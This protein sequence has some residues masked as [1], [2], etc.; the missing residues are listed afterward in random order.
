MAR[1]TQLVGLWN[2]ALTKALELPRRPR[3]PRR[4]LYTGSEIAPGDGRSSTRRWSRS[5][6]RSRT[7][8]A[9]TAA[10]VEADER[11]H[12]RMLRIVLVVSLLV[13]IAFAVVI[14][15]S[16]VK[17]VREL[18]A[19]LRSLDEHCLSELTAGLEAA[20]AGDFTRA[21]VTTPLA[22][23]ADDELGRLSTTFNSMLGKAQRSLEAYTAMCGELG[24]AD[25]RG[26]TQRRRGVGRLGAGRG[27]LRRGRPCRRRDR[28]RRHRRRPRRRAPGADGRVDPRPE[29]T[30]RRRQR[31]RDLHRR[32]PRTRAASPA[33]ASP[34]P[35]HERDPRGRRRLGRDR[36]RDRGPLRPLGAHRRDRDHDH[37]A[38]RAARGV[39]RRSARRRAEP[40]HPWVRGR[41]R[42]ANAG[43][44]RLDGSATALA[45]AG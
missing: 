11:A 10:A 9:A 39:E 43:R 31:R 2:A 22:V 30:G 26:L 17:P 41:R 27:L 28:Q 3:T 5:S 8:T 34:P 33:R 16:V 4:R 37:R 25:R 24:R 12:A 38:G 15:R 19:R 44:R 20:A 42:R 36:R 32:P 29:P 18:M 35:G 14:T 6:A 40:A 13:A 45:P 23:R 1:F 21:T 7:H